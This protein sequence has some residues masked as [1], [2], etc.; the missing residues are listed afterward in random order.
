MQRLA[1]EY[2]T[3]YKYF[4]SKYYALQREMGN[5]VEEQFSTVQE[6][7]KEIPKVAKKETR[8]TGEDTRKSGQETRRTG[9]DTRKQPE[10]DIKEI[11]TKGASNSKQSSFNVELLDENKK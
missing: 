5:N 3:L 7:V 6:E 1:D 2:K 11:K 9:E 8:R 4:K 10:S